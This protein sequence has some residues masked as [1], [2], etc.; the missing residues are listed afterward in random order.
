MLKINPKD[1]IEW[2]DYF[3]HPWII[4]NSST[5]NNN[6]SIPIEIPEKPVDIESEPIFNNHF[7]C[8]SDNDFLIINSPP[9]NNIS[10]Y[11][12]SEKKNSEINNFSSFYN[13]LK[14]SIKYFSI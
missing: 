14:R 8:I 11:L 5:N 1:R 12:T 3:N 7:H 10:Q 2:D 6:K 13:N 9:Q 4:Q